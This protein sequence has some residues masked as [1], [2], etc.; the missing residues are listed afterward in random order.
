MELCTA[1]WYWVWVLIFNH[2]TVFIWIRTFL[3]FLCFFHRKLFVLLSDVGFYFIPHCD[4][5]IW[6]SLLQRCFA[7][8]NLLWRAVLILVH[9]M[10][11]LDRMRVTY[12]TDLDK[13]VLTSNFEKRGWS[14]VGPDDDWNFYWCVQCIQCTLL[15]PSSLR[16]ILRCICSEWA[17]IDEIWYRNSEY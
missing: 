15:Q 3:F 1:G 12:C 8:Y 11:A 14:Q 16:C 4:V 6:R 10:V 13:S 9:R 5:V 2:I 17:D 7:A